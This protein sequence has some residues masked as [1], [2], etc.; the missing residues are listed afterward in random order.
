MPVVGWRIGP[1][2]LPL[3]IAPKSDSREFVGEDGRFHFDV[4][5]LS[6]AR[7]ASR[8]LSRLATEPKRERAR[9]SNRNVGDAPISSAD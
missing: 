9:P 3:A 6:A 5:D 2:K 1:M 8:A 7:R 4:R